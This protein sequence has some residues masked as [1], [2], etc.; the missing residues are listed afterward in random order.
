MRAG[1]AE[2][3]DRVGRARPEPHPSRRAGGVLRGAHGGPVPG[4][5]ALLLASA[6]VEVSTTDAALGAPQLGVG[7]AVA[8]CRATGHAVPIV[9]Y[10]PPPWWRAFGTGRLRA[11]AVP[12]GDDG[13]LL[14]L[15]L[16]YLLAEGSGTKL[17]PLGIGV[18]DYF[19]ALLHP[20]GPPDAA[21]RLLAAAL[22]ASPEAGS[23]RP[24]G[25]LPGAALR[26]AAVPR[27]WR[28]EGSGTVGALPR[29]GA[30]RAARI[31]RRRSPAS[32]ARRSA[33]RAIAPS[34][35]WIRGSDC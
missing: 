20:D 23:L 14:N 18:S 34:G 10:R 31:R 6:S 29:A 11:G 9:R 2:A 25:L 1:M 32:A 35:R 5:V 15:L 8:A 13:R 30:C 24:V 28:D 16:L 21:A 3:I 17:L 19:D 33:M 7:N 22:A 4:A 27:G 12:R 26:D